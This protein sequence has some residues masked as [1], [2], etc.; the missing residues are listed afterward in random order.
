MLKEAASAGDHHDYALSHLPA[1]LSRTDATLT[2]AM[3]DILAAAS[4][5]LI[6]AEPA[7]VIGA[8][9]G[10]H[11]A[12]P[13]RDAQRASPEVVVDTGGRCRDRDPETV[14]CPP[15]TMKCENHLNDLN[16]RKPCGR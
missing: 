3:R 6:E 16:R 15:V 4:Q 11:R 14:H 5:E 12:A 9:P 8:A 10:E 2:T 7:G 1:R 13:F